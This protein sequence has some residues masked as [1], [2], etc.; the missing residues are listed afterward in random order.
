MKDDTFKVVS[1]FDL[2]ELDSLRYHNADDVEN[3]LSSAA[4]LAA[5]KPLPVWRRVEILEKVVYKLNDQLDEFADTIAKEG[6]K[7]LR[8]ALVEAGRAVDGIKNAIE[9]LH[10]EQGTSV[11]MGI[12]PA[13]SHRL[14]FTTREPIGVVAAI[15]AFNHPLNLIVHQVVPAVA[16]GCPVIVK[17]AAATPLSCLNFVY[18]LHKCGLPEE[19]CRVLLLSNENSEALVTDSRV[20]FFS[21]IGS[22]R[23]GWYLRSKLA[24]GTRCALEHGG[25]A[26]VI[27]EADANLDSIVPAL[28]KGGYYHAGQVCVS[29]QRIF[30]HSSIV[31]ELQDRMV[32]EIKTLKTGDPVLP[33]TDVGPLILPREV[34]RVEEWVQEAISMGAKVVTGGN[35]ISDTCFEPTLLRDAPQEAKVSQM[36]IFGPVI[37]LM[38]FDH[39]ENAIE[40]ANSLPVAFQASIFTQDIDQAMAAARGLNASAVMINDHSAFRVDWM[41]FAGRKTSGLGIGGIPYTMQDMTQEKM[42]VFKSPAL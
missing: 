5:G 24:P 37:T 18:L 17:P 28:V 15:S 19:W 20:D 38:A 26:P 13:S 40:Q 2:S 3:C 25:A 6:G 31:E 27:V 32:D 29:V 39:M 23:V 10:S 42:I 21:F 16:V 34:D 14:A 8:D 12:N 7:P 4:A 9:V 1:P 35:R 36:E 30:A 41:P 22:S 33:T 11:P